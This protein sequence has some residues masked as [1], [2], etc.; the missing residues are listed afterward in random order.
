MSSTAVRAPTVPSQVKR[1]H[2]SLDSSGRS[3]VVS[4]ESE[5]S[6]V[7]SKSDDDLIGLIPDTPDRHSKP[8]TIPVHSPDSAGVIELIE[9]K[10][11][12]IGYFKPDT[13]PRTLV[14][15]SPTRV[16]LPSENL[17]NDYMNCMKVRPRVTR[18]VSTNVSED[19]CDSVLGSNRH[20]SRRASADID[21]NLEDESNSSSG[22]KAQ[23][24]YQRSDK[25]KLKQCATDSTSSDSTSSERKTLKKLKR[26]R[27]PN[28][29]NMSNLKH[30]PSNKKFK[31]NTVGKSPLRRIQHH[32]RSPERSPENGAHLPAAASR[33]CRT[34]SH[35]KSL[36]KDIAVS[37]ITNNS[38]S[39]ILTKS[40]RESRRASGSSTKL[41]S[42]R[43]R[44]VPTATMRSPIMSI[45]GRRS[46]TSTPAAQEQSED[47]GIGSDDQTS[48][49]SSSAC[50]WR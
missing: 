27:E 11:G 49:T 43:L 22:H 36:L 18:S 13:S 20:S 45:Q 24:T 46:I 26:K 12:F 25:L 34:R 32:N 14:I 30:E 42:P 9:G 50:K 40:K 37:P 33:H 4:C 17:S 31:T 47:S 23:K 39:C 7:S 41:S 5:D 10:E 1:S 19:S 6:G 29:S 8:I 28:P 3:S 35:V 48:S 16:S 38:P 21:P 44:T 2:G 15:P